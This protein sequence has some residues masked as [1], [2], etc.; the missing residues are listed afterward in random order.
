MTLSSSCP[1]RLR[2]CSPPVPGLRWALALVL[3]TLAAGPA[4]PALA[5]APADPVDGFTADM[6][7]IPMRDGRRLHTYVYRPTDAREPLP[8]ILLRTPYGIAGRPPRALRGEYQELAEDGYLFA[9]QDIRGR[10]DSEGEFVMNRPLHDPADSGGVDESTDTWDTVDWLVRQ[11]PGHNGAVGVIGV[12]YPGWLAAMA[13]IA[14]H[15]AVKAVSPQAPM[16]DTWMG[17]DFFHNGAFRLSYGFEYAAAMELSKDGS[18]PVPIDRYDTFDWYRELGPLSRIGTLL[19]G[20]VP[21]WNHFVAHPAYDRFWKARALPTYLTRLAVPTLTVGGWW[22]QEDF[23]GPLAT[24]AALERLDTAGINFLVVGPWNH[25]GWNRGDA[26]ALGRIHFRSPTGRTFRREI[27]APWFAHWLKGRPGLPFLEALVFEGGSNLWRSFDHWPPRRDTEIKRL[28]FAPNGRLAFAPPAPQDTAPY[29]Q[30]V[31]D[32]AHPVPYRRRPVE[33][34]YDSRGSGWSTWLVED[35]RFVDNRP[36]VLTWQTEPLADD[37]TIAG[38][39][40]AQLFASTTGSD[41]DWVV[42]LIDVYPDTVEADPSMGGYQLMVASEILRGRYRR[43]FERPEPIPPGRVLRYTVPLRQQCYR[44]LRGHRIM[45]Q[46]QS[47]WFPLYDRNP[48]RFVPN[49]FEARPGDFR[50]ATHRIWRSPR[51]PSHLE[52]PVLAGPR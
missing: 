38:D 46:V 51:F 41:A 43:S 48:Q 31:S 18:V 26:E 20:R 5:Q 19:R 35:Q 44:F 47:T 50:A 34:T 15:P 3:G 36:D 23:Y 8:I 39:L 6:V 14:P 27:Q 33:Q 17:D 10:Y 2:P 52:L 21:T 24:Y 28:Y 40:A 16:T 12:S 29:D 30:F 25:G 49:I 22:D 4:A 13:G 37:L 32:P 1:S 11:V 42:K 45:V 9:F 7:M